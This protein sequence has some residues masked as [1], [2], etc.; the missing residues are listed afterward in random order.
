[1]ELEPVFEN[2]GDTSNIL[3]LDDAAAIDEREGTID[4][5]GDDELPVNQE[6]EESRRVSLLEQQKETDVFEGVEQ[7]SMKGL[8][9]MLLE[10]QKTFQKTQKALQKKLENQ[11]KE[12]Q[13]F[14]QVSEPDSDEDYN[15]GVTG[16]DN[17]PRRK[18][19]KRR[20]GRLSEILGY[21]QC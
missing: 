10:N 1:M 20:T 2:E 18:K 19:Q 6:A 16:V 4:F 12:L 21:L 14:R 11:E 15:S 13:T 8:L 9:K 17:R 5:T 7:E 3:P